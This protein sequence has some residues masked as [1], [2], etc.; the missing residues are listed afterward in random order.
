LIEFLFVIY[1]IGVFLTDTYRSSFRISGA[2][3]NV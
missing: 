1:M 2:E 3:E